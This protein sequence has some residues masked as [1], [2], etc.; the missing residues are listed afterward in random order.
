MSHDTATTPRTPARAEAHSTAPAQG[1][2]IL[3]QAVEAGAIEVDD[4]A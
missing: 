4:A 1:Q 3:K 2:S